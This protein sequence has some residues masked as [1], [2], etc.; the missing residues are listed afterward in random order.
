MQAAF[1]NS[2]HSVGECLWSSIPRCLTRLCTFWYISSR[3]G[4]EVFSLGSWPV[5]RTARISD[6]VDWPRISFSKSVWKD[7]RGTVEVNFFVYD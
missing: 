4:V 2:F 3:G 1:I 5:P 7:S 6:T